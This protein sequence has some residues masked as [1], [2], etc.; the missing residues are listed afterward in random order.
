M[1]VD[2]TDISEETFLT[3]FMKVHDDEDA[4]FL[5]VVGNCL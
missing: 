4:G 3:F 5:G 1:A 2:Y